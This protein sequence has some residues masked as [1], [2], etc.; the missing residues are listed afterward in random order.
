LCKNNASLHEHLAVDF[1]APCFEHEHV[2][3]PAAFRFTRATI[4]I[5]N[6]R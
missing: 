6:M 1:N 4:E 3:H 2:V 5:G